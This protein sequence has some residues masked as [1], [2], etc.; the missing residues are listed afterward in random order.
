MRAPSEI[1]RRLQ[2][3]LAEVDGIALYMQPV[4]DLTIEDR[5]SRTQYQFTLEDTSIDEIERVDAQAGRSL[6]RGC[7]SSPMSRAICRMSG[8]QAYV[9]I[10][11]DDSQPAR[12]SRLAAVDNA[13]YNA[14]GQRLISTIFTQT[15]QYR[16]V[17]EAEAGISGEARA[18][19]TKSMSRPRCR[20]AGAAGAV[21]VDCAR[22]RAGGLA[23][24]SITSASFPRRR[25][26]SIWRRAYRWVTP[27]RRYEKTEKE[28]GLPASVQIKISGR[29]AGVSGVAGQRAVADPGR[30]RHHVHRAGR[31]VRKLYPP[32]HHSVDA[33]LGR[34]RCAA[35]A[36]RVG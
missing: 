12:A 20:T 24:R 25:F 2:T 21:V 32:G 13:L 4:Q 35:G 30:D 5:V 6:A 22:Q 18:R 28:I 26:R 27:S 9:D 19:S 8:L 3:K 31:A 33:A 17:L 10:D 16:V 23:V 36:D 7:R 29:G 1:I 14:F 11:R 34:G 15:N